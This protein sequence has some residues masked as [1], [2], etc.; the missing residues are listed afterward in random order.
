MSRCAKNLVFPIVVA[1]VLAMSLATRN[2]AANDSKSTRATVDVLSQVSLAGK[3][4]KPGTYTVTA[5]DSKVTIADGSKVIAEA[6]VQWKDET[7]KARYSNIVTVGDQV[8][9][10]HFSGKM[11]Y[12]Q[13]AE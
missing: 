10:I 5:D 6:P 9:E 13:I 3:Q 12:I 4:I 2:A 7:A 11:R 1:I 8:K